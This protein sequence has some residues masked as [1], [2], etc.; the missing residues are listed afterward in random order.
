MSLPTFGESTSGSRDGVPD[1]S[2]IGCSYFSCSTMSRSALWT[3][4]FT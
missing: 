4:F 2:G 1:V 3:R